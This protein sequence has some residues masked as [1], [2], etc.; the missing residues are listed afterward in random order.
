MSYKRKSFDWSMPFAAIIIA[1]MLVIF[2]QYIY[3]IWTGEIGLN[4][5]PKGQK[6][7]T[8]YNSGGYTHLCVES[9]VAIPVV[10]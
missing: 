8:G 6:S 3:E 5:C 10:P 1:L 2:G 9:G 4:G 7:I